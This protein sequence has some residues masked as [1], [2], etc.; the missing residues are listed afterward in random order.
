MLQDKRTAL[1]CAAVGGHTEVVQLLLSR[2]DVNIN[3]TDKVIYHCY[4]SRSQSIIITVYSDVLI[5]H[6]L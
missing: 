1:M 5:V 3:M 4:S 6:V 2:Q